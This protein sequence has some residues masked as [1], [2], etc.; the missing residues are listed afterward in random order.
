M[1]GNS[2]CDHRR[3]YRNITVVSHFYRYFINP[4]YRVIWLFRLVGCIK[5]K[6]IRRIVS[7]YYRRQCVRFQIELDHETRI[8][9]GL[10][11]VHNGPIVINPKAIIGENAIIHPCVLIGGDR[12]KT[13]P[14]IIG[15]NVFIGHGVKIIGGCKIGNS[16][17]LAPG[18]V[19]TKDV[20]ENYIM[21]AGINNVIS[22]NGGIIANSRYRS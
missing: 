16:V 14:P 3:N 10:I 1:F 19:I 4:S 22:C 21:G 9:P 12:S 18:A 20:P 2:L 13:T 11:F 17:F 8:K 6:V 5:N 7:I 15:D